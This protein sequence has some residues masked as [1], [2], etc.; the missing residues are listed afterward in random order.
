LPFLDETLKEMD[1]KLDD[2]RIYKKDYIKAMA[3]SRGW[4]DVVKN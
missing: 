4:D 3:K 2:K 1:V